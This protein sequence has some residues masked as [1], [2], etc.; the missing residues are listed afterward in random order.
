MVDIDD[1]WSLRHGN[2][3]VSYALPPFL[4]EGAQKGFV[5]AS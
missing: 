5:K 2:L 1:V 4:N 3:P